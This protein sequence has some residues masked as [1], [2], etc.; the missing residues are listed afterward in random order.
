[1]IV[2]CFSVSL[3]CSVSFAF[4]KALSEGQ[5]CVAYTAKKGQKRKKAYNWSAAFRGYL[6]DLFV[7]AVP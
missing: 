2:H 4:I 6:C 1:M 7:L 3:H 5:N